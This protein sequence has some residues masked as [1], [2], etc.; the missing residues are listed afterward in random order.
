MR[1]PAGDRKT[2]AQSPAR[3]CGPSGWARAHRIEAS[4]PSQIRLV[5]FLRQVARSRPA[6]FSRPAP[7][8]PSCPI[9]QHL[10]FQL[11]CVLHHNFITLKHMYVSDVL[12]WRSEKW[13]SD[14]CHV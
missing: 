1:L 5:Q 11:L 9:S 8:P 3:R 2:P 13:R 4:S 12:C 7:M 6:F 14:K 10:P